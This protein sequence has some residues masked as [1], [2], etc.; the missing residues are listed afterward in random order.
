MSGRIDLTR[1]NRG[2]LERFRYI[3]GN[4]V[5]WLELLRGELSRRFADWESTRPVTGQ[6][7]SEADILTALLEQ[8]QGERRDMLWEVVRSFARAS[9]VFSE[10]IDT[11]ANEGYLRTA[12]QWEHVRNLV[13]M[14]DYHPA[15]P[16]SASASLVLEVKEGEAGTLEKG[17]QVKH[18]PADGGATVFFETLADVE[19]GAGLNGLRPAQWDV[20]E[21]TL[22]SDAT[23]DDD[24]WL[25]LDAID[26]LSVGQLAVLEKGDAVTASVVELDS[27][28]R[29]SG[30]IG[31]L[32]KANQHDFTGWP[33]AQ[34][35]LWLDARQI[36]KA[37][38]NGDGAILLDASHGLMVDDVLCWFDIEW[39]FNR[40]I[41]AEEK[42]VRLASTAPLP[43]TGQKVYKAS[44]LDIPADDLIS[45]NPFGSGLSQRVA[46]VSGTGFAFPVEGSDF[47]IIPYDDTDEVYYE[48]ISSISTLYTAPDLQVDP[49]VPAVGSVVEL[50]P[51]G[52][53]F[54]GAPGKIASGQWLVAQDDNDACLPLMVA[55]VVE[56]E[57]SFLLTF[58]GYTPGEV[59]IKRIHAAFS[60]QLL[61]SGFDKNQRA[62]NEAELACLVLDGAVEEGL[63]QLLRSGRKLLIEQQTDDG[64]S[65]AHEASISAVD[66][67]SGSISFT[68]ALDADAGFTVGNT[69]I[70]ANVVMAGHGKTQ[71]ERVLGSGDATQ[72]AQ[73]FLFEQ[74]GVSFVA[75]TSMSSGV[76]ADIDVS[77]DGRIWQQVSTLNDSSPSDHHYTVRM[78]EAGGLD[79]S[80]GDG[81]HGR[82]LPSGSNN[83]RVLWRKG[84]GL[85]GNLAAGSL[86]KPVK[87]HR[88]LDAVRQPLTSGGGSD[89][90][91][92]DSLRDNAPA[93]VLALE[94]AV[95]L[96]DFR[97]LA[98]SHSS[99]WQA[100]AAGLPSGASR[101]RQVEVTIVPA[102]GGTLDDDTRD[103]LSGYI[104]QHAVPGCRVSVLEFERIPLQLEVELQVKSDAYDADEVSE[105]VRIS[106]LEALS[107]ENSVLGKPLYLS[108]MYAIV[109]AVTGVENASCVITPDIKVRDASGLE[110]GDA[111]L[112]ESVAGVV[113]RVDASA[114]QMVYLHEDGSG[115][116]VSAGGYVL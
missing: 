96:A 76:R 98:V 82:R 113:L 41:E 24:L 39:Q 66:A 95:S 23:S 58:S 51:S 52:F 62:L 33:I 5:H 17:F 43:A 94:R 93:S 85:E 19:L 79:I 4:A 32:R 80:F 26:D 38:L 86:Q 116:S 44:K 64:Y 1:W 92:T 21:T 91:G 73:H 16:A 114:R 89:M 61:P 31:L 27:I 13:E 70:H 10:T 46:Y 111:V 45:I 35:S 87:P 12:T 75:D 108:Q 42:S 109:E 77:V 6:A 106:L 8:Y 11:Y 97:H 60:K 100:G 9:H 36:H 29:D 67:D 34:A 74:E 102:G 104:E 49:D 25:A 15:P 40:V 47:S 105:A 37:I 99:V 90:E 78:I 88:L 65:Q 22:N 110:L 2:G 54:A 20:P 115:L 72:S 112:G 63:H 3:D 48:L 71:P 103:S 50:S 83:L 81:E 7:G 53:G 101:R 30:R 14:L 18:S 69:V 68:P 55:N 59:G 57:D 28:D 84:S 107:V 56:Q